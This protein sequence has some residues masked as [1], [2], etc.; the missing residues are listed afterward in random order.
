MRPPCI[1]FFVI[2]SQNIRGV[3]VNVTL[4]DDETHIFKDPLL[5]FFQSIKLSRPDPENKGS[6]PKELE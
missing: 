6:P 3:N 2:V 4:E 1:A 5:F